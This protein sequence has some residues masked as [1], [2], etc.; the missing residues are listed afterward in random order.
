MSHTFETMV[1]VA[2]GADALQT[3]RTKAIAVIGLAIAFGWP[4]ILLIPGVSGFS[5]TNIRDS[6]VNIGL[7]W[8]VVAGL[9]VIVFRAQG[10]QLS[11]VG[12]RGV[13]W[14]DIL[15]AIGG[16]IV[17]IV[18]SGFASRIAATQP[19]V[20]DLMEIAAVPLSLR[21]ALV[22]T[23]GVCEEFIYRA[24]AIEELTFLKSKRWLSAVV[25]WAFFTVS[26]ALPDNLSTQ[27]F[28]PGTLGAV[29]TVLYL[30]RRNLASC[31][32]MHA[33]VDAVFLVILP[34]MSK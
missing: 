27:L 32:L 34:A 30:W 22:L 10:R 8:L 15:A 7:K 28:V 33:I 11:E 5:I 17:G 23:A 14:R 2:P 12:I 25:T 19:S 29:L 6:V 16:A 21:A 31:A 3:A 24:F 18:L 26:H 20:N 4:L 1:A 9:C 13:G